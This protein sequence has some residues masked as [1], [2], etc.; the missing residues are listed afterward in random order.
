MTGNGGSGGG[1]NGSHALH[2][3][4]IRTDSHAVQYS[5]YFL[6]S[7]FSNSY[8]NY[9]IRLPIQKIFYKSGCPTE[10]KTFGDLIRKTRMELN[11]TAKELSIFLNVNEGSIINWE[12]GNHQPDRKRLRLVVVFLR[13]H[14]DGSISENKLWNLIFKSNPFYPKQ[15][16]QNTFGEKLRVTRM[17]RFLTVKQ[18]A[19]ILDVDPSSIVKWEI[20]KSEPLPE[21]KLKILNWI[22]SN[23]I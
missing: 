8:L 15:H 2:H 4:D 17:K 9:S 11:L 3:Q 14:L 19:K 21:Y 1:N 12:V 16:K 10:I 6:K 22:K 18:L 13:K 23:Y 7:P 20:S 5:N